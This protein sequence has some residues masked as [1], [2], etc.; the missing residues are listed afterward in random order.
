MRHNDLFTCAVWGGRR[1][2][3]G[4]TLKLNGG[5]PF[6]ERKRPGDKWKR[7][8]YVAVRNGSR[9]VGVVR[10]DSD[11][12]CLAPIRSISSVASSREDCGITACGRSADPSLPQGVVE[13]EF[14]SRSATNSLRRQTPQR[15]SSC[16]RNRRRRTLRPQATPAAQPAKRRCR[17]HAD[18]Q[19]FS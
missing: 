7:P 10:A 5:N 13:R 15:T 9:I 4:R 11:E 1:A 19:R 8:C 3:E 12:A 16:G 2:R 18:G 6:I 14:A 17:T